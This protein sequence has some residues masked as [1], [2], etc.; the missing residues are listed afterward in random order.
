MC[1]SFVRV[2][3][4]MEMILIQPFVVGMSKVRRISISDFDEI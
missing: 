3:V 2:Y 1:Q 4:G